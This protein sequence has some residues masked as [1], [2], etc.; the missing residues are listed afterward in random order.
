MGKLFAFKEHHFDF[1]S[2]RKIFYI[3]A[4]IFIVPGL[5]F[6]AISGLNAGIDFTGGMIFNITYTDDVDLAS[7]RQT[8]SQYLEQ[9]PSVN[10]SAANQFIIRTEELTSEQ[11]DALL[12]GLGELGNIDESMTSTDLIGP[13]IGSELLRNA[14]WALVIAGVLMLLYITIRF[15]FNYAITAIAALAHDVLVLISIFAIFRIEVNSEFI[16]AIL[17]IVG[18][19]INNT[20]V[21]FD[22]IRENQRL[23]TER[24]LPTL[25]NTSINQTLGRTINTVVALLI[26]LC[27]LFVLGGATTKTFV[28]ALIIGMFAGFYSSVFLVGNIFCFITKVTGGK[29]KTARRQTKAKAKPA[30]AK[31]K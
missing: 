28:L 18:Y 19:S 30:T 17:T 15:R 6:A 9:T 25:V 13:T 7:V 22:R 23:G 24:D 29:A 16:A 27:A 31:G 11:S 5:V 8:A 4:L 3:I 1:I 2:K 12:A 20:I 26:L 10:S 14:I 21:I